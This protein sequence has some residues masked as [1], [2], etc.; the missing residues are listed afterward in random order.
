MKALFIKSANKGFILLQTLLIYYIFISLF[1]SYTYLRSLQKANDQLFEAVEGRIDMEI[2]ALE[3]FHE[4][5][6]KHHDAIYIHKHWVTYWFKEDQLIIN[7]D[8]Y[9]DYN[10]TFKLHKDKKLSH[11]QLK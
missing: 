8:G 10:L 6:I 3:Y 5:P 11:R 9:Y 7:F 4:N 1:V 2:M